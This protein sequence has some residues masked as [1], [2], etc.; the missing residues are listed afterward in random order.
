[1]EQELDRHGLQITAYQSGVDE[2]ETQF[3][4]LEIFRVGN[5]SAFLPCVT[6]L[7]MLCTFS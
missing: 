2:T 5:S 6:I 4:D 3:H 7:G 1:L